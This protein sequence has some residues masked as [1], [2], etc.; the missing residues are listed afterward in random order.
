M[1]LEKEIELKRQSS[2][3]N[4]FLIYTIRDILIE[5]KLTTYEEFYEKYHSLLDASQLSDEDKKL[6][7]RL[8]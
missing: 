8:T 2:L 5:N 6:L 1:D 7:Q 3:R 4:T